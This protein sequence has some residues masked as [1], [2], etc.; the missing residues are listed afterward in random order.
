MLTV[1]SN[2]D[3][4]SS[5]SV[6]VDIFGICIGQAVDYTGSMTTI[7]AGETFVAN[8]IDQAYD[9]DYTLI[10]SEDPNEVVLDGAYSI[11]LVTTTLGQTQTDNI[12][13][14][15]FLSSGRWSR[16]GDELTVVNDGQ[17]S[18]TTIIELT[19]TSLKLSTVQTQDLSQECVTIVFMVDSEVTYTRM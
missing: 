6:N 1:R 4:S 2:D 9:V 7:Q 13:N 16:A 5:A 8:F 11:E 15:E 3:N 12:E 19:D 10:F 14:L 17:T 18:V